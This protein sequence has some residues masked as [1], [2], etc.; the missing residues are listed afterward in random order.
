MTDTK[1][2]FLLPA[3]KAKFLEE[4]LRSIQQQTYTD[5]KVIVSDDCSPEDIKGVFD[6]VCGNDKRFE[7]CRNDTNMGS[8]S[9]VSHWN[10]L[11]D[12]CDTEFLIMASDDDVYAPTFLEEINNLTIKYPHIDL[13]RARAQRIENNIVVNKDYN[14]DEH[15]SMGEFITCFGFSNMVLCLA[16]Y[17]F[18]TKKIKEIGK[19]PNFPLATYSDSAAAI[20]M[21]RNGIATT[22]D[23][24]FT[25]RISNENLSSASCYTKNIK[26]LSIANLMFTDWY[27]ENI[28]DILKEVSLKENYLLPKINKAHKQ[29]VEALPHFLYP[30]LPFMDMLFFCKELRKRGFLRDK[31]DIYRIFKNWMIVKNN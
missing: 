24:L 11:V 10:L 31:Y 9:L 6:K 18:R 5:F 17:T 12:M 28:H 13:F 29:F 19:F 2:T 16:N 30:R 3:Y 7:Y 23:I 8:K 14:L 1:Y 27:E 20:L 21:A 4:S 22:T 26:N 25:F 15:M